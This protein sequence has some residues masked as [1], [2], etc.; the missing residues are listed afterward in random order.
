MAET[1]TKT[2]KFL[3]KDVQKKTITKMNKA[4]R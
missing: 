2:L 4:K 1:Y 3:K